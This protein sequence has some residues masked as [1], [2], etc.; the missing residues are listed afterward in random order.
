MKINQ[1]FLNIAFIF[2]WCTV[3]AQRSDTLFLRYDARNSDSLE[4]KTDTL[5]RKT[6]F[7][8]HFLFETTWITNTGTQM[9]CLGYG[10]HAEKAESECIDRGIESG[11]DHLISLIKTDSSIIANYKIA[12]NCCFAFLC[13]MEVLDSNTLNLKHISYGSVCGCTCYHE[14]SF[15]ISMDFWDDEYKQNFDKLQFIT[16]NGELKAKLE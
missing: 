2:I 5:I 7:G 1:I 3:N 16:L 13:D 9:E 14:L 12:T 15:E 4:Y 6:P 10:L 8:P 11:E